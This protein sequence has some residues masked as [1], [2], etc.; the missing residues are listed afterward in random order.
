MYIVLHTQLELLNY[1]KHTEKGVPPKP[2]NI[3]CPP[4]DKALKA[5]SFCRAVEMTFESISWL[6]KIIKLSRPDATQLLI[7]TIF[8]SVESLGVSASEREC[9]PKAET[10]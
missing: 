2:Y 5:I 4:N 7:F 1:K 10:F 8:L 3:F 6:N 9:V